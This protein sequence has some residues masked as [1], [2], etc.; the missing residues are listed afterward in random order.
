LPV[1]RFIAE[2]E[3][4][5]VSELPLLDDPGKL[6]LARRLLLDGVVSG[7]LA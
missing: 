4:F 2:R 1:F 5:L 6:V 3:A 7:E